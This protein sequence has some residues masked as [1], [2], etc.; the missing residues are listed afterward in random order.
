MGQGRKNRFLELGMSWETI[1]KKNN[2]DASIIPLRE[3]SGRIDPEYFSIDALEL[4]Q[5]LKNKETY[6]LKDFCDI[7]ASAFYPAATHLYS[8]G[9]IPFARCVDCVDYPVIEK[10]QDK[11]FVRIPRNFLEK[12][13]N[14]RTVEKDDI[15]I[16][17]V[18]TPC[19]ASIVSGYEQIA[20]SRTVLGLKK[21]RNINPYYLLAFLRSKYGFG[22]LMRERELTIQYQLTLERTGQVRIAK[23]SVA[24]ETAIAR[25]VKDF[26]DI[27]QKADVL[28]LQAHDLLL[29]ELKM[30]TYT[31]NNKKI[32]VRNV[33]SCLRDKRFDAEYWQPKY[34]EIENHIKAKS[35]AALGS[36]VDWKKGI[37]VGS[38]AY[39]P[40]GIPFIR[41]SNITPQ[42]LSHNDEKLISP[43][44]Y[45][46]LKENFSPRKGEIL[47]SKD[48]TAGI[49][50]RLTDDVTGIISGGIL[51]LTVT[52]PTVNPDYLAVCLNSLLVQ[53]QVERYCGG[54]I[55]QH[56]KTS[57][58]EKIII[59]I[60]DEDKQKEIADTAL[61]SRIALDKARATLERAKQAVETFVERD[62]R[63]ALEAI[64]DV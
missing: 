40:K 62:E 57:D 34:D 3:L 15:I 25:V 29:R 41:I 7:T 21:I 9:E 39:E 30:S 23:P 60:L 64:K 59:P 20:L 56:L 19:F 33:A 61:Q 12:N 17:K 42:E 22:Q 37:E 10:S 35:F 53:M 36:V 5:N 51:R 50:H 45:D 26:S 46:T 43:E 63:A 27:R 4:I 58:F 44:L 32:S 48:G 18:G 16:T 2:L 14:V 8:I 1:V 11:R 13:K 49:A 47:F 31:A 24:L 52:D 38:L 28:Y 54:S 6:E 55:I